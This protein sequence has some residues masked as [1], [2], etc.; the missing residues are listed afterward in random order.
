M[1]VGDANLSNVRLELASAPNLM[2]IQRFDFLYRDLTLKTQGKM[3]WQNRR[4]Q[5]ESTAQLTNVDLDQFLIQHGDV[6][7]VPVSGT[8]RILSEGS[9]IEELLSNATGDVDLQ[10]DGPQRRTLRHRRDAD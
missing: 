10:A 7:V 5:L 6:A 9:R 4:A 1:T 2:T 3:T 8:V